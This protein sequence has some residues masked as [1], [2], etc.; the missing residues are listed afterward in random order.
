ME[1]QTLYSPEEIHSQVKTLANAIDNAKADSYL[2]LTVL[3]GAA[4][5]SSD[6]VRAMQTVTEL[7]YITATSYLDDF[8]PGD[9][10]TISN[11]SRL[12]LEG[13]HVL[14]VEDII[15]T[16]RTLQKIHQTVT[17]E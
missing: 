4:I 11:T 10:I 8:T 12:N 15:D 17:E 2:V 1:H 7:E 9:S 14:I 13:R 3:K 6:L 16:G 5:F